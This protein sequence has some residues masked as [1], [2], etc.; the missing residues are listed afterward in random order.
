MNYTIISGSG[1]K[2]FL[3]NFKIR[4]DTDVYKFLLRKTVILK[5]HIYTKK[6]GYF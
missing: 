4:Y 3:P 1:F 6:R 2:S 5:I